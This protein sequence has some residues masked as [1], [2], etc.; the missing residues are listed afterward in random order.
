M[1]LKE[2]NARGGGGV[3]LRPKFDYVDQPM[4]RNVTVTEIQCI[5]GNLINH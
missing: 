3:G 2:L 4:Y 1:K 5:D